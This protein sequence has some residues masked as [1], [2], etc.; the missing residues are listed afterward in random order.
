MDDRE[1]RCRH[2]PSSLSNSFCFHPYFHYFSY[3]TLTNQATYVSRYRRTPIAIFRDNA[4]DNLIYEVKITVSFFLYNVNTKDT[5]VDTLDGVVRLA[6]STLFAADPTG[7]L[8][9]MYVMQKVYFE[10]S[11]EHVE[12][13]ITIRRRCFLIILF[14]YL[15]SSR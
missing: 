9:C 14:F 11:T 7:S 3:L 10:N 4:K 1:Q 5:I 2:D 13:S 8:L 12:K 15:V 6:R